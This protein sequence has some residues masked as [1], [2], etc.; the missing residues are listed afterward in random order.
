MNRQELFSLDIFHCRDKWRMGNV[1]TKYSRDDIRR[2]SPTFTATSL[3]MN[4]Y[5]VKKI[6]VLPILRDTAIFLVLLKKIT[7]NLNKIS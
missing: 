4:E 7:K 6:K 1:Q 5:L 3:F 2:L